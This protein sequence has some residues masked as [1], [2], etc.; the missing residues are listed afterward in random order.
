MKQT[1]VAAV[2]CQVLTEVLGNTRRRPVKV[3][4][5]LPMSLVSAYMQTFHSDLCMNLA[6]G[7]PPGALLAQQMPVNCVI[8]VACW[9]NTD[10]IDYKIDTYSNL[11]RIIDCEFKLDFQ[12]AHSLALALILGFDV[13][14]FP[15][16]LA[17][18][19]D[20]L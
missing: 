10:T 8:W 9:L 12:K 6:A 16:R 11:R 17:V 4:L 13:K 15:L 1:A 19:K 3:T 2:H 5:I 14:S 7:P 18:L 20:R